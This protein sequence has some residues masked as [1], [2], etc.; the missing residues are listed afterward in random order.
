[1]RDYLLDIVQHTLNLGVVNA[2][3]IVGTEDSTEI[4]AMA[5]DHTVVISGKFQNPVS[6]FIGTF[7]I[8]NLA[9]LNT[10]LNLQEYQDGSKLAMTKNAQGDI[11]GL[12]FENSSG[13]FKNYYRFMPANVV[14]E[15]I[16][17]AQFVGGK[18]DLEF[19]PSTISVQRFKWQMDVHSEE[20]NFQ[21]R[22]ENSNL[23]ISF[24]SHSS[25]IGNFIFQTG[26]TGEIKSTWTYP[27]KQF[28]SIMSLVGDKEIKIS[29]QGALK[30][31]VNSGVA[32]YEYVMLALT[33]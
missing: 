3:K 1:M 7:G 12:S 5:E 11:D 22:T 10:I 18:W 29:D 8:P 17:K 26:I 16:K 28:L 2:V 23:K 15:R 27:A 21:I 30:I 20:P 9:K 32:S 33:K 6:E 4:A 13:D 25:H 19:I 31:T 24:G 14:N